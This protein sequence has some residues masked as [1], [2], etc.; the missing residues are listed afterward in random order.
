M[1]S[2]G[3]AD[4]LR[5]PVRFVCISRVDCATKSLNS[6]RNNII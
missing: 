5:S 2:L 6:S 4:A 1:P 3:M